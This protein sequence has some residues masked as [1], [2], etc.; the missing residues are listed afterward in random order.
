MQVIN[1]KE[2]KV[3]QG[4]DVQCHD[5][6][7]GFCVSF[8][9]NV[10]VSVQIGEG[11]YHS[12]RLV[13][14]DEKQLEKQRTAWEDSDYYKG[15]RAPNCETAILYK[16]KFLSY[17]GD[18]VQGWQSMEQLVETLVYAMNLPNAPARKDLTNT[19]YDMSLVPRLIE[20]G[21]AVAGNKTDCPEQIIEMIKEQD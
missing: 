10:E 8:D 1:S 4:L 15:R 17:K 11:N 19:I 20:F 16:G 21:W 18:D 7:A 9:N 13:C 2:Y 5:T 14:T 3:K 6:K 12:N